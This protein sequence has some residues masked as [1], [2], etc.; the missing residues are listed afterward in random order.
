MAKLI[1]LVNEWD[2]EYKRNGNSSALAQLTRVLGETV[3]AFGVVLQEGVGVECAAAV[4]LL[5]FGDSETA[6]PGGFAGEELS[7]NSPI[8][9]VIWKE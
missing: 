7:A 1:I 9:Q 5:L 6:L 3:Q 8:N 4:A 2:V